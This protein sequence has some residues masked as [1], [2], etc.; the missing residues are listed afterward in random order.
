[1]I[2]E[3]MKRYSLLTNIFFMLSSKK[4]NIHVFFMHECILVVCV[5]VRERERKVRNYYYGQITTYLWFKRNLNSLP[6]V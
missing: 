4:K 5:S 1:M 2:L 6:V 3:F